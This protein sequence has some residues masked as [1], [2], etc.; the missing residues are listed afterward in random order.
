ML[1]LVAGLVI[2]LGAHSL[3]IVAE[4][5]R[6]RW[7]ARL[8]D[9]A[10]KL[11]YSVVSIV[12]FVLI[13]KG[14]DAAR[15]APQPLWAPPVGLRHF[16]AL[17]TV[18]AFV[19]LVA[20][21]VPGNSIRSRLRHP[22]VLGVK[23]WALAHL[24]ANHTLADVVLFG[25]FLVWAVFSYRAARRRDAAQ[26]TVYAPG[27]VGPTVVTVVVGLVA[28]AL[29]AFWAHGAWIGIRPFG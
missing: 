26:G 13:V 14:Y 25:S 11:L 3:R 7:Q 19:L 24:I 5:P 12:G 28:W 20:P 23:L 16:A 18:P 1:M 29:F 27:R 10:F 22:M 21:Y 8:G 9:N 17:L 15:M 2:F 6:Q 4:G